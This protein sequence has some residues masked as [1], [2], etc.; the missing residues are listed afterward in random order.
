M[1]VCWGEEGR[2][3]EEGGGRKGGDGIGYSTVIK[4]FCNHK[5]TST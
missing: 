2:K 1:Q 3:G 4:H 5:C